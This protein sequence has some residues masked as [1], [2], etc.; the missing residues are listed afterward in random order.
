MFVFF[1]DNVTLEEVTIASRSKR[2]QPITQRRSVIPRR[3]GTA[4]SYKTV[5]SLLVTIC[6]ASLTFT[7]FTFCPRSVCICFV[8]ISEQIPIISLY[9][10]NWLVFI[11][12]TELFTARY[13]LDLYFQVN[14]I[15]IRGRSWRRVG[16]F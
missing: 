14:T 15:P 4:E 7:N 2:R 3:M 8:W 9:S 11:T 13:G 5:Y 10:I 12:E 16:T 6:T 1:L